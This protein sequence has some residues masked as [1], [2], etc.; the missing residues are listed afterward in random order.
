M[1]IS[2]QAVCGEFVV[3]KTTRTELMVSLGDKKIPFAKDQVRLVEHKTGMST[4][5]SKLLTD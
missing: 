3:D 4:V 2:F 1:F 5:D